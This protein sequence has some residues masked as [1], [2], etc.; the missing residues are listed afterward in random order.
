MATTLVRGGYF[1]RVL[2]LFNN[3]IAL[4]S[5]TV[6]KATTSGDQQVNDVP[7]MTSN[8]LVGGFTRG[9]AKYSLNLSI[10]PTTNSTPIDFTSI[11]YDNT[12]V[13][14]ALYCPKGQFGSNVFA[15]SN[16]YLLCTGLFLSTNDELEATGVGQ[17]VTSNYNFRCVNQEWV[18]N[19]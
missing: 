17:A 11:D 13:T 18:S 3:D 19:I 8:H 12:L 2:V 4:E 14:V 15:G 16:K 5:D 9:N 6:G 10:F 7:T 1:E